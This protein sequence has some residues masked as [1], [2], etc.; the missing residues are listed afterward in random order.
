MRNAL[1]PVERSFFERCVA[2]NSVGN[3]TAMNEQ[4]PQPERSNQ[5]NDCYSEGERAWMEGTQE[6]RAKYLSLLLVGLTKSGVRANHITFLS[7][8]CGACFLPC[9]FYMEPLAALIVL[10][11]HILIDGIDG[12]LARHQGTASGRGSFADSVVDQC[13]VTWVT[14][15]TMLA[16]IL[17]TSA[18][19][20][21]IFV[22]TL[23]VAF[24]MIRNA[25][26]APFSWLVRPRFYVYGWLIV[27][28]WY[29]PGSLEYFTW[30][31]IA[32]LTIKAISGFFAIYNNLGRRE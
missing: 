22:Y 16:G 1:W 12:P 7:F 15:T 28:L 4:S 27:E 6:W 13:I 3:I 25:M 32:L 8:V 5:G 24:A 20:I 21:Y 11:A 26:G 9:W 23:V 31:C 14:L 10:V 2:T 19:T 18:G 29:W 30:V 17:S